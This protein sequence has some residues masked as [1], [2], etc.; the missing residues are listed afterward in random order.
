[1]SRRTRFAR[2]LVATVV[3]AGVFVTTAAALRFSDESYMVSQ[4]VAGMPYSHT[5]SAPPSGTSGAGCDPPYIFRVLQGALPPGLSLGQTSGVVSGTPTQAGAWSFWV[6]LT[7][8]PSGKESWCLPLSAEREF[9]ISILPG[10]AITTTTAAPGT[11]GATYSVALATDLPGQKA[12]SVSSGAL[13]A[14]LTLGAADGVISGTPTT[15]G[16]FPFVVKA[17]LDDKRSDTQDLTIVVRAPVEIAAPPAPPSE[18]GVPFRLPLSASG[19][20]GA[21]TW[22]VSGGALPRGLVLS[23]DGT[24]VGTPSLAGRYAFTASASDTEGRVA[25]L[26]ATLVVAP[27]LAIS[28]L[29]LR[30]AKVG[31]LYRAKLA[32]TGGVKPTKWRAFGRLP[33]GIRLDRTLGVLSGTPTKPGR[34]RVTFKAV[35]ALGVKSSKTLVISVLA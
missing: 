3:L 26:P 32:T 24:I 22:S 4:G 25:V 1:M 7:D 15:A 21:Y 28:T 5:F 16:S 30:Q 6:Q 14:G 33:R 31:R 13:P 35:D 34:Y 2:V 17:V 20:A 8:D 19:G 9:T 10:L 29:L 11:V 12:W 23:A 18:V 27:K